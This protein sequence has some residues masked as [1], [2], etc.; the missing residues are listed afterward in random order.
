MTFPF[1]SVRTN[2]MRTKLVP[3]LFIGAGMLLGYLAA[4]ADF[5]ANKPAE[6]GNVR[7]KTSVD[8]LQQ[9]SGEPSSGL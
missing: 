7:A 9:I 3:V 4:N 1:S 2:L 5:G 8:N 6:A